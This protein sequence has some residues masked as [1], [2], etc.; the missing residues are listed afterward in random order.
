MF[1]EKKKTTTVSCLFLNDVRTKCM[2]TWKQQPKCSLKPKLT[3]W[4]FEYF[5]KHSS[6]ILLYH[7]RRKRSDFPLSYNSF[8]LDSPQSWNKS[9]NDQWVV[10]GWVY[11]YY[12]YWSLF[13]PST[14]VNALRWRRN[15]RQ[16]KGWKI[17][18]EFWI[19][20]TH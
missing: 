11:Y 9:P 18:S 5:T 14:R 10:G 2:T 4:H 17:A 1:S 16:M 15:V 12:C 3:I 6:H 19:I 13:K 8:D 20:Q 7:C